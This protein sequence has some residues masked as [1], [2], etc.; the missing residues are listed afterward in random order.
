MA[1]DFA[2]IG[3]SAAWQQRKTNTGYQDTVQGP[4]GLS[5]NAS[6]TVGSSAANSIYVAQ[7]TLAASASTTIDLFSFTDQL[8]QSVSMVRVYSMV[9][10]T[11][12]A[13]LKVEPGATNPLTW[14]FGGTTPSI[15][16]PSNGGF[17]FTQPTAATVSSTVRNIKLT[18]TG[19]VTLTYN[20]AIIGGP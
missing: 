2:N 8:G 7:G 3:I 10:K 6:L 15:T 13:A 4:D 5:L 1:L 18:N 16:I 17:G 9:V 11:A 14:F 20:I 19:A 12:D